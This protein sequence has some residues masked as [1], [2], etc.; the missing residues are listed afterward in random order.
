ITYGLSVSNP[1]GRRCSRHCP[2][3][4]LHKAVRLVTQMVPCL[5]SIIFQA[6]RPK[7][8]GVS[9]RFTRFDTEGAVFTNRPHMVGSHSRS[10]P[11]TKTSSGSHGNPSLGP[12]GLIFPETGLIRTR[13]PGFVA[14][15][16]EPSE[17]SA[18]QRTLSLPKPSFLVQVLMRPTP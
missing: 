18:N 16:I 10:R 6:K 14:A 9:T 13:P 15:Q 12:D 8:S 5:S 3:R 4:Q 11:S 17:V 1:S 2:S 7:D